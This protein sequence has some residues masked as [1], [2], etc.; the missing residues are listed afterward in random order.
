MD[1]KFINPF[2]DSVLNILPMLG[3]SDIKKNGISIQENQIESPGV[4]IIVGISGDIRG[5]VIYGTTTDCAKGI[6]ASMMMGMAV[7]NFDEIAQSAISELSNMLAANAATNFSN[8]DITIDIS[9]PTLI[10]GSFTAN[11]STD[12]VLCIELLVNGLPFY[13]NVAIDKA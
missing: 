7:E 10:Y 13:V 2:L 12:K 8:M 1:V 4:I 3:I 6:A 5:N 9:P 11:A